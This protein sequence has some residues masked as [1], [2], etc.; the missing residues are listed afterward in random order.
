VSE[1]QSQAHTKKDELR[2]SS[3]S[4]KLISKFFLINKM[5]LATMFFVENMNLMKPYQRINLS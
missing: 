4:L 3:R 2:S 5:Q 1:A